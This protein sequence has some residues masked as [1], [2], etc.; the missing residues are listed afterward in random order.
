LKKVLSFT[1]RIFPSDHSRFIYFHNENGHPD[2][3]AYDDT[4][5]QVVMMSGLPDAGC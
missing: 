5:L 2:Y 4:R 1:L 3:A